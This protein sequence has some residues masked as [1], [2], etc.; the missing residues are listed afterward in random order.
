M[1][2]RSVAALQVLL[3]VERDARRAGTVAALHYL[4]AN[5]TRK[6]VRGRQFF[7]LAIVDGALR[8]AAVSSVTSVDREAPFIQW[9][10][11]LLARRFVAPP[12]AAS[13]LD[14]SEEPASAGDHAEHYPFPHL[15]V[16]PMLSG[17][18]GRGEPLGV[19]L[20]ARET[21]WDEEGLRVGERLAECYAH[22]WSAFRP[23]PSPLR[24]LRR[25]GVMAGLA[26]GGFVLLGLIPTHLTALAPFEIVPDRP[27]VVAAS[28]DGTIESVAVQPNTAVAAGQVLYTCVSTTLRDNL[29][30]AERAVAV[31]EAKWKQYRQ[32]AFADPQAKRELA[33]AEAE[34]QLKLAERDYAKDLVDKSVTRA[35]R[36]GIVL[37]N[38]ANDLAGRPVQVGQRIMEI[39]DRA[40]VLARINV[41]VDDSIVL[42]EDA[43]GKGLPRQRS[44][45][46]GGG[47]G[48]PRQPRRPRQRGQRAGLPGRREPR[49]RRRRAT[50]RRSRHRR[51][52]RPALQ[53][54]ARPVPPPAR[55]AAPALWLL[56]APRDRRSG[57]DRTCG[58]IPAR[59]SGTRRAG[60]ST[61]PPG[62]RTSSWT[63][64]PS[65]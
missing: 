30:I 46:R 29:E 42:A 65:R 58:S 2:P 48:G 18:A 62:T 8:V 26:L 20:A 9:V 47:Q 61:I 7:V 55:H 51:D 41:P 27:F 33:S 34:Y 10:E 16:L 19:L 21:P 23:G 14:L 59:R 64:P 56:S 13:V 52:L 24:R 31:A 28:S 4:A 12:T 5:E 36:A 57:S 39:A 1:A 49:A 32:G 45:A 60:R 35:P 38:D 11:A 15:L 63:P 22:A 54:A 43:R 50:P 53:P 6:L 40:H 25:P 44:A 17:A 37:F 3:R